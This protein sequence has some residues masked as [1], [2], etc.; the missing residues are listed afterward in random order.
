MTS[1]MPAQIH[2]TVT[3]PAISVDAHGDGSGTAALPEPL[4]LP[5]YGGPC[6]DSV[7]PSLLASPGARPDWIP[8]P[9][10]QA[11]QV[12]LLV[13]DGLGWLQLESRA[14]LTPTLGGLEGGPISSVAPTTTATALTSL[15]LG[16]PPAAHGIVGYKFVVA[17]PSGA[18]EVLNVLRWSTRSGDARQFLPPRGVQ[19]R[20][21]FDGVAVPV[22]SKADFAN[23]GFTQAHQQGAREVPWYVPSS[24][25]SLVRRLLLNGESLVY[26]YYDGVDRVAHATGFGELYDAELVFVDW[27]VG[28]ILSAM[29]VGAVLAVVADHGQV[30]VG[31]RAALVASEVAAESELFSG[32]ARFRWLHSRPGEAAGLLEL[33]RNRYGQEAWVATRQEIVESGVFGGVPSAEALSR[34]GD[35]ALIP[36]GQN[37]YLD[38]HD[39]GDAKLVCRHGGLSP[40]EVLVP[41]LVA[42]AS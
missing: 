29:P 38:P 27:L 2:P 11:R 18:S 36:L 41:L 26:A 40:E 33:A 13:L 12:V 42:R 1:E 39:S 22:V 25:P 6:L 23:S 32:E 4:L 9:L 8:G 16:M 30:E 7:T 3:R 28:E 10:R 21:A 31:A 14:H 15:A 17:G 19:P 20:P 34:L 24:I 35:V 37:G 5:A